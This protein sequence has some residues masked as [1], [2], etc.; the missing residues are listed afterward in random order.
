[1]EAKR[2]NGERLAESLVGV[3]AKICP[4]AVELGTEKRGGMKEGKHNL[5]ISR[6]GR[7]TNSAISKTKCTAWA[8]WPVTREQIMKKN[9]RAQ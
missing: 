2:Q 6:K 1:V 3:R 5:T 7:G 4:G 9:H 8:R